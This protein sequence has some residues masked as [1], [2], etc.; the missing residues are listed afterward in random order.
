M[1]NRPIEMKANATGASPPEAVTRPA[2]LRGLTASY[3]QT[4]ITLAITFVTT[5]LFLRLLGAELFGLWA[6]ISSIL[7]YF[8]LTGMGLPQA[9]ANRLAASHAQGRS[10][11][12]ADLLVSAAWAMG[13]LGAT[14]AIIIGALLR[15]GVISRELFRG[16][17][18]MRHAAMPVLLISVAG[19]ILATPLDQFRGAL[20]AFQRVDLEQG[21]VTV[22]RSVSLLAGGAVLLGGG[23]IVMLAASQA[24][25]TVVFSVACVVLIVRLYP[26]LGLRAFRFNR[27]VLRDLIAPSGHFVLLSAAGALIWNSSNIVIATSLGTAAVTP[28]AVSMRLL[29]MA[30]GWMSVGTTALMP[31]TTAIW[32]A[33]DRDRV[34]RLLVKVL[35]FTMGATALLCIEFAFNGREFIRLWAGPYAG[36]PP[37][38]FLIL[39]AIFAIRAFAVCFEFV[40]VALSH[41]RAY[42]YVAMAEGVGG[43][44]LAIALA[45]RF[46]LVGVATATLVAHLCGSGWFLPWRGSRLVNLKATE[47]LNCVLLPLVP[48]S[49]VSAACAWGLAGLG[50]GR[51]GAWTW[52]LARSGISALAFVLTH[53]IVGVNADERRGVKRRVVVLRDTLVRRW[54]GK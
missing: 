3:V 47:T 51:E 48:A 37:A 50:H 2:I 44:V 36:V 31:A 7:A 11:E 18:E 38:V 24:V 54:S 49:L 27:R 10:D 17:F 53:A 4:A 34:K 33:G 26:E 12:T 43:L 13:A 29:T 23:G 40:I 8:S 52:W 6:T 14:G 32:S 5:P 15:F 46:G 39:I 25:T 21:I 41:H 20:R 42:A 30:S 1:P 45:Q 28:Y 9:V 19:Y 35:R 16:S 22:T